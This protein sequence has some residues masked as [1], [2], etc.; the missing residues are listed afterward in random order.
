MNN[1]LIATG[2]VAMALCISIG[3]HAAEVII[4]AAEDSLMLDGDNQNNP[5]PGILASELDTP[6]AG[7]IWIS[8]LK[9][10]LSPLERMT[11]N[12]A[13]F[14]LTSHFNHHAGVFTHEVYSSSDDS[15]TEDTVT[16]V[17]RPSDMTLTLLDSTNIGAVSQAYTW[18]VSAGVTGA[19]GLAGAGKPFDFD[20]KA[21]AFP[22]RH[23]IRPTFQ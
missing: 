2:L 11:I 13:T 22:G 4:T 9:F 12:S 7:N 23:C 19:D 16:G 8:V 21:R 10:D 6:D 3:A 17:N 5:F 14:E 1:K 20:D 18:D 15:W